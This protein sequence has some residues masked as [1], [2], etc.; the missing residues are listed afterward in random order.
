[1]AGE[2][3]SV[4]VT[5]QTLY[6]LTIVEDDS[7]VVTVTVPNEIATIE[8]NAYDV[9]VTMSNAGSGV[10]T[11]KA[12]SIDNFVLRSVSDDDKTI[13]VASANSDNE[14]K[15]KLPDAGISTPDDF[16]INADSDSTANIKLVGASVDLSKAKLITDLDANSKDLDS[17][18][19]ITAT[20]GDIT[21]VNSTTVTST[22]GTITTLGSTTGNITTVNS[23]NVNSTN[24]D[25]DTGTIDDLTSTTVDINGGSIDGTTVGA[26]TSSTGRFS[27]LTSDSVDLNG[28]AIDGTTIGAT[29]PSTIV[30]TDLTATTADINAGTIDNTT[31][32]ATTPSTIVTT[33]LTATTA[34][35]N[36]GTIDGTVVGGS[37]PAAVS[38]TSLVATTADINAGTIDNTT[39]GATTPSTIVTTN[40]TATTADINAGTID[41]SVIGATT[42]AAVS[43]TSLVATTADINAGTIDNSVI[44]GSTPV[45]GT[46]TTATATTGD[47]TTVNSTTGNITTVNA[48]DVNVSDDLDVTDDATIGGDLAVTGDTVLTGNLTVNGTQTIVNTE[49]LTVDDNIIVLNNNEAGTPSQNGGIEIERGTSDNAVF[50]W[51]EATDKWEAKVGSAYADLKVADVNTTSLTATTGDITNMNST[52]VNIDGGAIDGTPIGANTPSTIVTTNLTAT[53]AD[54]NAGTIDNTV[55]GATTPAAITTSSLIATTVDINGG[56][57]DGVTFTN[58]T[59]YGDLGDIIVGK[60]TSDGGNSMEFNTDGGL[61][62]KSGSSE[63]IRSTYG[64]GNFGLIKMRDLW[65]EEDVKLAQKSGIVQIGSQVNSDLIYQSGGL[66]DNQLGHQHANHP[67][68]R[69]MGAYLDW[70]DY[71]RVENSPGLS[72]SHSSVRCRVGSDSASKLVLNGGRNGADV[73]NDTSTGGGIILETVDNTNDTT[74]PDYYGSASNPGPGSQDTCIIELKGPVK[75]NNDLYSGYNTGGIIGDILPRGAGS[76]FTEGSLGNTTSKW[77]KLWVKDIEVSGDIIPDGDNTRSLGSATKEWKDVYIGP[78]SLYIDGHKVLGSDATDTINF[79]TDTGQTLEISA[80]GASGTAGVIN[81]AS[82]GNITSLNDTTVNLGPSVG[83]ATI[84]ARGTLE[85]SDLHN[86]AL[87]FSGT[88]INQTDTNQNLEIRT[89]GTGYLHANVADLYVGPIDGAVKIDESSISVSNTNGDL[90]LTSNG[91]GTV[92]IDDFE[93]SH[94]SQFGENF[95]KIKA[96]GTDQNLCLEASNGTGYFVVKSANQFFGAASGVKITNQ[97]GSAT[98]LSGFGYQS[99]ALN[100]TGNLTGPVVGN[101]TG[102]L[103]GNLT[104]DATTEKLTTKNIISNADSVTIPNVSNWGGFP[105]FANAGGV[106]SATKD[107]NQTGGGY[108]FI[109]IAQSTSGNTQPITQYLINNMNYDISGGLSGHGVSVQFA[110]QDETG[111]LLDI[112]QNLVKLRNPVVSGSAGSSTV[113][114]YNGEYTLTVFESASGTTTN[115][116]VLTTNKDYTETTKE[117][118]VVNKPAQSGTPD[119]SGVYLTYDGAETGTP[120]AKIQLR[121]QGTTTTTSL[122]EL[123]EAKVD[124][125]KVVNLAS[126]TT[127]E[128]NALTGVAGDMIFNST[129]SKFMGYN[130]SAWVELG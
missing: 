95:G 101:V 68:V 129:T 10:G 104:A 106:S 116:N 9:N 122:I 96:T 4:T 73:F 64:G 52:N 117:L 99:E 56:S 29:T 19:T 120:T 30:T 18:G 92:N 93:V 37:T 62:F 66:D 14:I 65:I 28:G 11:F 5:E 33:D 58:I 7:N 24:L 41:N 25:V 114:D 100:I 60:I 48:T 45:A 90:N 31:I 79:S 127:T 39:I 86:G 47:I 81:M 76:T 87:E 26:T 83:G 88:L 35:I 42:P 71:N 69:M 63:L 113:G 97:A 130:G 124:F 107:S 91:T 82:R 2:V 108:P 6:N 72:D 70:N 110:A 128:Q 13:D 23:T 111:K 15:V 20:T 49:T 84:N 22:G 38:T 74:H 54:I 80:G 21:T 17:V 125:K 34:D 121:N 1:M 105:L 3:T 77:T 40:L 67:E 44:G 98:T 109:G 8:V 102:D 61:T 123:A 118:R 51:T 89:N 46:F 75:F 27:T 57:I 16:Q 112:A 85:A 43:T 94:Y 32:G 53:T 78:G 55:I 119:L 12:K 103:T 126:N 50:Q 115:R 36:G 59:D